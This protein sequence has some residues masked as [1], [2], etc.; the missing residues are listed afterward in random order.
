[1]RRHIMQNSSFLSLSLSLTQFTHKYLHS[2]FIVSLSQI[3]HTN[4]LSLT[5]KHLLSISLSACDFPF[6][7]TQMPMHSPIHTLTLKLSHSLFLSF[8][9]TTHTH[10]PTHAHPYTYFLSFPLN[11]HAKG[12]N[13]HP[14]TLSLYFLLLFY[15]LR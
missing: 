5:H 12:Q 1:M 6:S 2:L 14:L 4:T 7:K 3:T 10:P 13:S 11:S 15:T 8:S 9:I